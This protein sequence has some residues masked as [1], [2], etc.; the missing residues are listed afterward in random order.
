MDGELKF[1]ESV[2]RTYLYI[3]FKG[4]VIRL[5]V[6]S[7]EDMLTSPL[8]CCDLPQA[9]QRGSIQIQG[10]CPKRRNTLRR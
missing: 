9:P 6:Y 4:G 8:N 3:V 7:R 10:T 2:R 5:T 1:K